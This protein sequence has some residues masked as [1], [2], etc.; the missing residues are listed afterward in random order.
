MR[1]MAAYCEAREAVSLRVE[2]QANRITVTMDNSAYSED[3][4][5]PA[6]LTLIFLDTD[7]PRVARGLAGSRDGFVEKPVTVRPAGGRRLIVSVP[8]S[9]EVLEL[10]F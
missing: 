3:R 10:A 6:E 5:G 2:R 8:T 9:A 7:Q 1:E 4:Y